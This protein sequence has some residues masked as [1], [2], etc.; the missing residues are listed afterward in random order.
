LKELVSV[1]I[2][3]V[4]LPMSVREDYFRLNEFQVLVPVTLEIENKQLSYNREGEFEVARVGIYGLVTSMSNRV[5]YEFDDEVVVSSR[6]EELESS[7]LKNSIYQRIIPVDGKMRYKLDLVV[8]DLASSRVG[9]V[10]RAINPPRFGTDQLS[11]SSLVLSNSIRIV[12]VGQDDLEMFVL[13]DVKIHPSLAKVFTPAVPL[14]LYFQ[15]Y[16]AAL[17]EATLSPH[18]SLT[19]RVLRKGALVAE[20]TDENGESTHYFSRGRVVILK[21][22]GLAGLEPGEYEIQVEAADVLNR[23]RLLL[24]DQFRF[25]DSE[26]DAA[27]ND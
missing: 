11:S 22:L 9:L 24:S 4:T 17:D 10:Q 8:K 2:D 5:A 15:L 27:R 23:Q 3:Y 1:N 19:F 7:R 16:N 26:A 12:D 13:G 20:T 14:G 25:V 21:L 6:P 18:L